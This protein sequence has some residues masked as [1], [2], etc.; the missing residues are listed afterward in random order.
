M[1]QWLL[2]HEPHGE[3]RGR[4]LQGSRRG[5]TTGACLGAREQ[6]P[7]AGAGCCRL[8]LLKCR[9]IASKYAPGDE[10]RAECAAETAKSPPMPG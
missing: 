9:L 6:A 8:I 3:G 4:A 2:P 1:L 7:R 5:R 10:R